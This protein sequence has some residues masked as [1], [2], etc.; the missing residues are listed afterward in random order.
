[1][2]L[3]CTVSINFYS[4]IYGQ[5]FK[6]LPYKLSQVLHAGHDKD[7]VS[8]T[9]GVR[10]IFPRL[11]PWKPMCIFAWIQNLERSSEVLGDDN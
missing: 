3:I 2:T 6:R 5:Y 11:V 1:M 9:A 4:S 8:V 10:P 7:D